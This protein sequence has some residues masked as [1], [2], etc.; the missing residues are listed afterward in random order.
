[1]INISIKC[2]NADKSDMTI[3]STIT[4]LELKTLIEEKL[5]VAASQQR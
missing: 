4:V 3:D 1:M 5:S 2:S